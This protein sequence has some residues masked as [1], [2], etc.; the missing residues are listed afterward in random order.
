MPSRAASPARREALTREAARRSAV[1]VLRVASAIT[2]YA[3]RE[4]A[5]GLSPEQARVATMEA[6]RELQLVAGKLMALA[7]VRPGLDPAGRRA[8]AVELAAA[9]LSQ[10][11]I[12]EQVGRSPRQVRDYLRAARVSSGG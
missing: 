11:Q 8:L 3:S 10:R 7:R 1:D 6:A 12:A 4:L 5:N 2:A 9:G